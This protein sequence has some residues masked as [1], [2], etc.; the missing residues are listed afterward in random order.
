L[1]GNRFHDMVRLWVAP[2]DGRIKVTA[3]VTLLAPPAEE[4]DPAADGVQVA[5]QLEGAQLWNARI[6]PGDGQAYEPQ[7]VSD[8]FV[9]KGER[10]Y[11][12]LQSV[13][14]G[15]QDSV[16]WQPVIEYLDKDPTRTDADGQKLHRYAV[17]ED[18]LLTADQEI[19]M[20][21]KGTVHVEGRFQ[22]PI[23]SDEVRVQITRTRGEQETVVLTKVY[24]Y[25]QV[26]DEQIAGDFPV[27]SADV[28]KFRV[29]SATNVAWS[30]L[31][32]EPHLYYSALPD[33][34]ARVLGDDGNPLMD[35]YPV[36]GYSLFSATIRP[37]TP[38]VVAGE[39][40]T[41]QVTPGF[42]FAP[43]LFKP[44]NGQIVFSVKKRLRPLLVETLTV[45]NNQAGTA[46][47]AVE[48]TK[49]DTLY[50]DYHATDS[51]VAAQLTRAQVTLKAGDNAYTVE[52]GIC[53]RRKDT[54]LGPLY[55]QW[56]TL[57]LQ[58]QPPPGRAAHQPGR[59]GHQPN[60]HRG[61]EGRLQEDQRYDALQKADVYKPAEEKFVILVPFGRERL[62]NGYDN[63]TRLDGTFMQS[64]RYGATKW[65]P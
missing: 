3:P 57:L 55:R 21:T 36:P 7:N 20:P 50:L 65:N 31:S 49:G 53:F 18:F 62:W 37:A 13:E 44:V 34:K 14:N 46:T 32:W 27:D 16:R 1:T 42:A 12:R 23:T 56:G 17:A 6:K 40:T 35:F 51:V 24:S 48:V 41:L 33:P 61:Q 8:L 4:A 59:P 38:F 28:F 26:A 2:F 47:Y 11:F 10:L 5:V 25:D 9:R 19:A 29:V 54:K 15:V 63:L 52:G 64:S 30:A 43:S 45:T 58:R 39:T 60:A 22:K